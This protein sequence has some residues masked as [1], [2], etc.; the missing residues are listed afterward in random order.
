M[1]PDADAPVVDAANDVIDAREAAITQ[2][3]TALLAQM[4]VM[5][6]SIAPAHHYN[7][8][9]RNQRTCNNRCAPPPQSC[10]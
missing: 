1:P 7:I 2:R 9:N 6:A 4:Q 5:M 3:E 8:R 10:S